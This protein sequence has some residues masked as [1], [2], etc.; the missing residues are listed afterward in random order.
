MESGCYEHIYFAKFGSTNG[1]IQLRESYK[2]TLF[3][4]VIMTAVLDLN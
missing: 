1:T 3:T 2:R 4:F